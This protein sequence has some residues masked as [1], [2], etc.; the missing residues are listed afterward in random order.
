MCAVL[1]RA[2]RLYIHQERKKNNTFIYS[3]SIIT[4]RFNC[5]KFIL[6]FLSF[7][8][9]LPFFLV[10]VSLS[11]I[12]IYLVY[13]TV[14]HLSPYIRVMLKWQH[15]FRLLF[16]RRR[17]RSETNKMLRRCL[18]FVYLVEFMLN[19]ISYLFFVLFS[20]PFLDPQ[21]F[22]LIDIY[23]LYIFFSPFTRSFFSLLFSSNQIIM[24]IVEN[25]LWISIRFFLTLKILY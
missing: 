23:S 10:C 20:V 16:R 17:R 9:L 8:F 14:S 19:N 22:E 1:S 25:C 13:L 18:F 3:C 15:F 12:Y 24:R 5:F 4:F 21:N 11:H 2:V 7:F 6:P